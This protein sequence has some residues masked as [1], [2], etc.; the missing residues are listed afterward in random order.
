MNRQL[1][2]SLRLERRYERLAGAGPVRCR[3]CG[4]TNP[5]VLERHHPFG[6]ANSG[7]TVVECANCHKKLTD[8]QE[9]WP[10]S[11]LAHVPDKPLGETVAAILAGAADL[12]ALAV[13]L[14]QSLIGWLRDLAEYF[15][16]HAGGIVGPPLPPKLVAGA[17]NV[18]SL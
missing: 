5:R 11:L 9:D 6:E 8:A 16:E 18:G 1:Q 15:H 13:E 4:E 17:A 7:I 10:P 3:H 14:F 2:A 12:L